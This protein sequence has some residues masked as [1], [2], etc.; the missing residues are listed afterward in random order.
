MADDVL[1]ARRTALPDQLGR[2]AARGMINVDPGG[3]IEAIEAGRL[4]N[5]LDAR[6]RA[7]FTDHAQVEFDQD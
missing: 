1:E 5:F 3:A 2:A 4:D 6:A 7:L